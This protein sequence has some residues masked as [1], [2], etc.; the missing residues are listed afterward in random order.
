MDTRKKDLIVC[1]PKIL[2]GKPIVKDTRISVALI[3]HLP[4]ILITLS[5]FWGCQTAEK[6]ALKGGEPQNTA[7]VKG[8]GLNEAVEA[9]SNSISS[10]DILK[11][12]NLGIGEFTNLEGAGSQLGK[13]IADS[14]EFELVKLSS[15]KGFQVVDRK[16]FAQI[17]KE[18]ELQLSGVVD[19]SSA[20]KVGSLL[21]LDVLTVG[22]VSDAGKDIDIKVKLIDTENGRILGGAESK[23]KKDEDVAKMFASL[24]KPETSVFKQK[25]AEVSEEKIK[26]DLWTDQKS[27]KIGEK[28]TVNFKADRDCYVTLVDVGTSGN[29]HILFPNRFSSGNK[30][31]ANEVYSVPAKGDG[32]KITVNGPSGTEIIRAIATLK[33]ISF[34]DIDF[35][36]TRSIFKSVDKNVPSFTR[37]L[38]IEASETPSS[39][40]GENLI[41]IEIK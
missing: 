20:K 17:A 19:E 15:G 29:V 41:K 2:S 11:G 1:N 33:P 14:I 7:Q 26:I 37:D 12:K 25:E 30:V 13:R 36:G 38:S 39:N 24:I 9:I 3:L 40:L 27:Y 8:A 34:I 18:W 32:Y 5:L 28:L 35:S 22:T 21:G 4:I 31:K 6:G 10:V 16:N 23:I